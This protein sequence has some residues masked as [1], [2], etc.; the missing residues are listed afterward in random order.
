MLFNLTGDQD[1][2]GDGRIFVEKSE[3]A[4]EEFLNTISV[5][6]LAYAIDYDEVRASQTS[7]SWNWFFE[8]TIHQAVKPR[9]ER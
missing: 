6:A 1:A 9:V 5:F 2:M 3:G 7:S 4:L 8:W